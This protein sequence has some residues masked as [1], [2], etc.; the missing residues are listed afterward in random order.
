MNVPATICDVE[1]LRLESLAVA[2]VAWDEDIREKLHVDADLSLALT[3]F[4]TAA[5]HV[6]RKMAGRQPSRPGILRGRQQLPNRIECLE[7]CDRIRSGRASDRR[8]IHQYG[9]GDVFGAFELAV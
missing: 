1:D 5:R 9:I 4:A 6:E 3:R 7:V 8:L 2:L